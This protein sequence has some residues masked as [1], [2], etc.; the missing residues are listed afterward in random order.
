MKIPFQVIPYKIYY[1][2]FYDCRILVLN[3]IC[4]GDSTDRLNH[5]ILLSKNNFLC[6][7][8]NKYFIS[9]VL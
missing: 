9:L 6:S 8:T 2:K 3:K 4:L 5:L 1:Y 7:L